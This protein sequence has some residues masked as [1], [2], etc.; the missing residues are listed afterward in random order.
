VRRDV[1]EPAIWR[2]RRDSGAVG[3][4]PW[5]LLFGRTLIA[6]TCL[7]TLLM[8][9]ALF[10]YWGLFSWLPAFLASPVSSG[11]AGMSVVKSTPWLVV[12]QLGAFAGY[13]SFG[14]LADRLGRRAAFI[15]YLGVAAVLAPTYGQ[16]GQRPTL[17]FVLAPV[18]GFFG[19]GYFSLFGSLLAELFPT[20]I[21]ATG[22]A[23]AYSL[24]RALSA[25]APLTVGALATTH[26]IGPALAITSFAFLAAAATILLIPETRGDPLDREDACQPPEVVR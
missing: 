23:L 24:G 1:A 6:R 10:G 12:M 5:R 17:L 9:T 21:R 25:L 26:G 3:M 19:H 7:G 20:E 11:G 8:T 4:P 18:L 13:L 22:Q 2:A 16:L 15:L 14:F